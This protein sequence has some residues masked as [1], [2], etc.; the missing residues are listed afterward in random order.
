VT[1]TTWLV[2]GVAASWLVTAHAAPAT[3]KVAF[4]NIRSGKGI[5]PLRGHAAPFAETDNCTDR[6]QPMNAWGAGIVQR[7]L[8]QRLGQDPTVIALGL[9]E[10][11]H[12]AAPEQVR[13]ALGWKAHTG[14]RNG[15]A[16]VTRYGMSGSPR[17]V[18][19][20]TSQN[21]NPKDTMWIVAAAVCL[22]ASCARTVDVYATHWSGT[23]ANGGQTF[24]QQA[25][26]TVRTMAESKGP[27]VL[28]GDLNVFE[29]ASE[30]CHQHPN[31]HT[32]SVLRQA[33]YVDA[34]PRVR[35]DAEGYTGMVNR[36]GCGHPEGA[37]WKR[38]DY[39]WSRLSPIAVEQFGVP[40]VGDAGP[41]D[42]YGIVAEYPSSVDASSRG[43]RGRAPR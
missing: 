35:G 9:A 6:G 16:I 32:L 7:E 1:R 40:P 34:W 8:V 26:E 11:W 37:A 28:V 43:S 29:G 33:G 2:V 36:A 22:D 14:E 39:V 3:F 17:W 12:C 27:H 31:N 18:Q 23:G 10:A 19:L 4:Y 20:D 25:A 13:S 38:I 42:H 21:K 24:D 41:S 15:T 30:V 5:Q